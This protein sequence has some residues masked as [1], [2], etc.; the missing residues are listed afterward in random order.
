[1]WLTLHPPL[2]SE[3]RPDACMPVWNVS[4]RHMQMIVRGV[5]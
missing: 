5:S 3:G 4:V 1:M 2:S